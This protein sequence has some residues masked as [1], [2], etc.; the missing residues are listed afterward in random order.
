MRNPISSLLA[1]LLTVGK[2]ST[3]RL[4]PPLT[5]HP[6]YIRKFSHIFQKVQGKLWWKSTALIQRVL[7]N[8]SPG[9]SISPVSTLFRTRMLLIVPII[10]IGRGTC[11]F[12]RFLIKV[13][14]IQLTQIFELVLKGITACWAKIIRLAYPVYLFIFK[15]TYTSRKSFP[16]CCMEYMTSIAYSI[17]FS[18]RPKSYV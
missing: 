6:H 14:G 18:Q 9:L 13:N 17:S 4:L 15:S 2:R 8:R 11:H 3:E 5:I 10:P 1:S 12:S 7:S 16:A